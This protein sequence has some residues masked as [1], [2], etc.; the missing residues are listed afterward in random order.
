[1]ADSIGG[2]VYPC[3][4]MISFIGDHSASDRDS[5]DGRVVYPHSA[6]SA[7]FPYILISPREKGL[8]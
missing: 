3:S 4:V 5:S 8:G 2:G 7:E 6:D 1:M